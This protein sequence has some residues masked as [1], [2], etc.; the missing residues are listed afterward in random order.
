MKLLESGPLQR[1]LEAEL[2]AG[3][4]VVED[5]LAQWGELK[6]VIILGS[7]FLSRGR[8][9]EGS[10]SFREINDP[11]YWKAEVEDSHTKELVACGFGSS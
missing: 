1:F 5:S 4:R 11:H 6:R 8:V 2:S 7:P 3:N 9:D 10:L